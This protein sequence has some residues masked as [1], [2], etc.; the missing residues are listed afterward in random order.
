MYW[1]QQGP[2]KELEWVAEGQEH[3]GW[4]RIKNQQ[5]PKGSVLESIGY[6]G[7]HNQ[8]RL[9]VLESHQPVSGLIQT[10]YFYM[11]E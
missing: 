7:N 5:K 3:G 11:G 6:K 10:H 1:V 8:V 4:G 2:R 9:L